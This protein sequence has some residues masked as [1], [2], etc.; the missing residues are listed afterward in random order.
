MNSKYRDHYIRFIGVFPNYYSDEKSIA[1]FKKAYAI[2]FDL[3]LDK[4]GSLQKRLNANITPEVFV[5]DAQHHILYSGR[6]DDSFYALGK[7]RTVIT[8]TELKD[9]LKEITSG[10]KVT[11]PKT[12]AIGCIISGSK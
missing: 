4:E 9:A 7:R 1:E 12:Q 5:E 2:P 3:V 10:K 11:K 6:I 8:S